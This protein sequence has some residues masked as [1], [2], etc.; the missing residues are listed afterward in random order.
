MIKKTIALA[1]NPNV[2]KSTLFNALTGMH[3]HT[4]N[5]TGKTVAN[6]TG[7]MKYK[8]TIFDFVDLPGT[9]TLDSSSPDERITGD[10]IASKKADII[11]IVA[12]ATCLQR[13]LLLVSDILSVTNDV[14]LCVNLID[15]AEKKGIFLDMKRLSRILGIPVIS[16]AARSKKGLGHL[17]RELH[18]F[19][20][21]EP[22]DPLPDPE[23]ICGQ[24]VK[25]TYVQPHHFDRKLDRIVTS[26]RF[27]FPI[28]FFLL[29]LIFWL[30]MVGAN[31]PST[32]LS[33]IFTMLEE[34]LR[35]IMQSTQIP[36]FLVS[37]LMDGIYTTLTWVI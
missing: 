2:G 23:T 26:K 1:G 32:A 9:Y 29:V 37:M 24:C 34:K 6:A 5:W 16:T 11:L 27:G 3:Q 10:Y 35:L 30:T 12:D 15:E 8:D 33:A 22:A 13:N 36:A 31:Y 20:P 7:Q 18:T 21:R 17:I 25:Q 4:G 28:M 19:T 14:V